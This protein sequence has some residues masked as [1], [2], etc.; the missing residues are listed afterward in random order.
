M[1]NVQWEAAKWGG[2]WSL[3]L[4]YGDISVVEVVAHSVLGRARGVDSVVGYHKVDFVDGPW[5]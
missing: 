1:D 2:R 5:P 3:G 4:V